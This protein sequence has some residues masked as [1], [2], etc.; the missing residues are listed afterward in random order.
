M[1]KKRP[2][3]GFHDFLNSKPLL[4]PFRH[5][6]LE[7]PFELVID[8]PSNLATRFASGDLDMALIP[9]IEYGRNKDAVIIPSACIASIGRVE[10][11]LLFSELAI[12]DIESVCVDL[13]SR[14]SVAML[15]ILLKEKYGKTPTMTPCEDDPATMLRSADAGLLI[16]DAAYNL[17]R[18]D[19][20]VHDLGDLWYQH[21]GT[22]FVHAVLCAKKGERWDTAISA[23]EEAKKL[24]KEHRALIA[25]QETANHDEAERLLDYLTKRIYY[26]LGDDEKEGLARFLRSAKEMKIS[27]RDNLEFY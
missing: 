22:P 5:G 4:H 11:V 7:T 6:L 1:T 23:I 24:G 26:D 25:K 10:T 9:S 12:E 8:T 27:E 14:T 17:D 20:V 15:E 19:Y 13:K 2:R 16:G 3:V 18:S 21:S